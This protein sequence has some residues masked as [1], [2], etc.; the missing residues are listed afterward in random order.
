MAQKQHLYYFYD[1]F[2]K[3]KRV[4]IKFQQNT[5]YSDPTFWLKNR[6][7]FSISLF[8]LFCFY[9]F[10]NEN[11]LGLICGNHEKDECHLTFDACFRERQTC[12]F[13][14]YKSL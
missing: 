12:Y 4:S 14:S 5:T 1:P 3:E 11:F 8:F 13:L 9:V 7:V 2:S 6:S 10:F